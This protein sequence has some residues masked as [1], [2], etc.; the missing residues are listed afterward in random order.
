MIVRVGETTRVPVAAG[1]KVETACGEA[2]IT[3]MVEAKSNVGSSVVVN[4]GE[5][6][7]AAVTVLAKMLGRPA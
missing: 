7:I 4:V 3:A 1:G 5:G 2:V 6:G